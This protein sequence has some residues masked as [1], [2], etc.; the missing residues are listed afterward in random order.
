MRHSKNF[1]DSVRKTSTHTSATAAVENS[2]YL[3]FFDECG[4]HS[5]KHIDQDFPVFV[6]ATIVIERQVYVKQAVPA[7]AELKVDSWHHEGVNIHNREIRKATGDFSFLQNASRRASFLPKI[8]ALVEDIPFHLFISAV[9]KD[10][11]L[12]RYG[13]I[14]DNPYQLALKFTME[15]IAHLLESSGETTLPIIAEARGANEDQDL[16]ATFYRV[17]MHGTDFVSGNRFSKLNCPITFRRKYDNIVGTQLADLCAHPSA[18]KILFP[19]RPNIAFNS[20][21]PKLYQEN[22]ISGWKVFP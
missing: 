9:R 7:F 20:V 1:T 13:A 6:L 12:K 8:S 11:H 4:D 17:M 14:A 16:E 2:R 3:A 21:R 22:G 15:R 10:L 19:D 5:L 18:R